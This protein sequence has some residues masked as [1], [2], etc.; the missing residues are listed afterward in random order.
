MSQPAPWGRSTPRWSVLGQPRRFLA[1]PASTP[2]LAGSRAIVW[3]GPPLSASGPSSG[4][5]PYNELV[6]VMT[7]QPAAL[8]R[9]EYAK[10]ARVPEQSSPVPPALTVLSATI[11]SVRLTEPPK[12]AIP[13]PARPPRLS[14]SVSPTA[15]SVPSPKL[16]MPAPPSTGQCGGSCGSPVSTQETSSAFPDTV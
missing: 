2:G 16:A 1:G 13:P 3:V 15:V 14:A 7:V 5:R 10:T 4:S 9:R 11:V 12:T 8:P 6:L